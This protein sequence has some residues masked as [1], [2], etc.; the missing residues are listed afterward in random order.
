[1]CCRED[2]VQTEEKYKLR[3][4]TKAYKLSYN[5]ITTDESS[6]FYTF[7]V[8]SQALGRRERSLSIS[9][10]RPVLK[11]ECHLETGVRLKECSPKAS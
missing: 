7:A 5:Y 11:R 9:D 10:T 2:R 4:T 1:V 8:F 6:M 3:L